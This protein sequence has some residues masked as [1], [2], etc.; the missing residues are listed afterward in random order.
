MN[1]SLSIQ[2]WFQFN[3]VNE[4]VA[5]EDL[6]VTEAGLF[7]RLRIYAWKHLG[8][9]AEFDRLK[10][11]AV[12]TC[13][14]SAYRFKKC[15][16]VV[17]QKFSKTSDGRLVYE[18]DEERRIVTP[19]TSRKFQEL[20]KKGAEAR[21]KKNVESGLQA[22]PKADSG[23]HDSAIDSGW[24]TVDS[25]SENYIA[26][27]AENTT[28]VGDL[29]RMAAAV[30]NSC[31]NTFRL[32]ASIFRDVTPEFVTRLLSASQKIFPAVTDEDL[33][34]AVRATFKPGKQKSAGL[35]L[36]T[37]PAWLSNLREV[38]PQPPPV[39]PIDYNYELFNEWSKT[40]GYEHAD[41]GD[42]LRALDEWEAETGLTIA[43]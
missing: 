4:A 43:G 30:E 23:R 28:T 37:V 31:P 26:A 12:M 42:F 8:L 18:P 36:D 19:E 29:P 3:P 13:G 22:V 32:I 2:P 40:R 16:Q 14:I 7:F 41:G 20:G 38:K 15:W 24:Q 5:I 17:E 25:R 35:F 6:D 39:Q 9:P 27:T 11:I 21:W 10:K 34:L 33:S 1:P